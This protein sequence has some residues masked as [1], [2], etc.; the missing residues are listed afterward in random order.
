MT[1]LG[2]EYIVIYFSLS[3]NP[4][5]S[6]ERMCWLCCLV[7]YWWSCFFA[8][9]KSTRNIT[10]NSWSWITESKKFAMSSQL[11]TICISLWYRRDSPHHFGPWFVMPNIF[12]RF[13]NERWKTGHTH[14]DLEINEI[15]SSG[16]LWT[17]QI[18]SQFCNDFFK[19]LRYHLWRGV[20]LLFGEQN[21]KKS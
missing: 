7:L 16:S 4:I 12:G 20:H 19:L 17:Q 15:C 8:S 6:R 10:F 3:F 9:T 18:Q 13:I 5:Q 1:E 11:P 14:L 2:L 21:E